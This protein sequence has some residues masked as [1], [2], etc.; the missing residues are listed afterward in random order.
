M[1][2]LFLFRHAKSSWGEPSLADAE[3]PLNKRGENAAPLMGKMMKE[4]HVRPDIIIC[5]PAKR[6]RQTAK[7]SLKPAGLDMDD[8]RYDDRVYLASDAQLLDLLSELKEDVDSA[9]LI[10]HNPGLEDLLQKLTGE[11][12]AMATAA[13]ACISLNIKRW[14]NL[15]GGAGQLDWLIKPKDLRSD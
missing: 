7:L 15:R 2:T 6:T 3:R 4:N 10:G 12:E 8:V 13:L 11:S 9:M 1:K 14:Q 5:S